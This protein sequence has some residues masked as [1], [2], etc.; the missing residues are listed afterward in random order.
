MFD[1]RMLFDWRMWLLVLLTY[2]LGGCLWGNPGNEV[3][4]SLTQRQQVGWSAEGNFTQEA[5]GT[6][7][8]NML[9]AEGEIVLMT[10]ADGKPTID[11]SKSRVT[12]ILI[13]S[14]SAKDASNVAQV[15]AA[16]STAQYEMFGRTLEGIFAMV[17][18]L[19]Q[20]R[21]ERAPEPETESDRMSR[22]DVIEIIRELRGGGDGGR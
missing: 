7:T 19:V 12:A 5:E 6:Q 17:V 13:T 11:L 8:N 3:R 22:N 1:L 9:M 4:R 10:D 14:P 2:L 20:A 21:I 15:F 16:A 18:P